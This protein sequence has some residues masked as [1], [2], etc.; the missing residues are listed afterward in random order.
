MHSVDNQAALSTGMNFWIGGR[1]EYGVDVDLCEALTSAVAAHLLY[2]T[3]V[4]L[5][6]RRGMSMPADQGGGVGC[7]CKDCMGHPQNTVDR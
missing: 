3:Q 7:F 4:V 5:R 1:F 6:G 2:L